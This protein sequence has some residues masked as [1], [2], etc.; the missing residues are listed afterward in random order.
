MVAAALA[1]GA[2]AGV[3]VAP[4]A[5]VRELQVWKERVEHAN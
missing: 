2:F 4:P 3:N 5:E 1:V